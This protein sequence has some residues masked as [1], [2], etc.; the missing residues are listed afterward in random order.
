MKIILNTGIA[1]LLAVAANAQSVTKYVDPYI[2]SGGHGHVFVGASVPFGAVQAGPTNIFK[3]WDWDSGYNYGDSILIGFSHLHL[4]GTGIGDLGDILVMPYT[5]EIK[6]DKGT[7]ANHRSGY[8]SLYSHRNEVVKPGFYS[9]LLEDYNI[10]ASLTATERVGFHRYQFPGGK[11]ARVIVDLKEGTQDKATETFIEKLN[12]STFTGYRYSTGWAK[13]Q[14]VYFAIRTSVPVKNFQVYNEA[15]LLPGTQGKG[16]AGKGLLSFGDGAQTVELKVGISPV[17]AANA[18]GNIEAEVPGWNFD[19]VAQQAD[20]SWN[21]ELSKIEV[22]TKTEKEKRIFYTSLYHTMINPA[23]YNDHNGDYRGADKKVYHDNSFTNYTILSTWDTYRAAH[24]L[25]TLIAPERAADMVNTMLGIYE[26]QGKLPKWHLY[27]YETGTMVGISSMQIVA[28]AYLKGI[29][30]FDAER[31]YKAIKGTAM[32]DS[33]GMMFTKNFKVI[34]NDQYRRSVATAMENAISDASTALMAKQLGH[35][36]DYRYFQRRAANYKLYFDPASG[37]F[38]GRNAAGVM[39]PDFNPVHAPN[40]ELAEGNSW[41]YLWL[42]PQDVTGL[43]TLLGGKKAMAARLDTF[44]SLPLTAE[45]EVLADLTG[46]I[47]Q[48][49]HGN[50][51]GHHI[52]YLYTYVGQPWKTAEKVR[53]I[54]K[55]MYHDQPDGIIGN[56]DCGQ[57]G[58][59]NVFSAMGFYPVFPASGKYVIGSPAV[60]KAVIHTGAG[61]PFVMEAID[62]SPENIYVQSITLNGKAYTKTY[63]LHADLLKGGVLKIKMGNKPNY[64]FGVLKENQPE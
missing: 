21:K 19:Q 28:E 42:V 27:G 8:A 24:P 26:Q 61:E 13:E 57:M 40:P 34:P 23:M 55:E 44:F 25:Y 3:G 33:L 38:R 36:E 43:T 31:A 35:T 12:D 15:Q 54:M 10:R 11:T 32:S 45:K 63:L 9:V 59:W 50:E 60:D 14:Q 46:L 6:T 2:G 7:E 37:F 16:N 17:S 29:K 30:G 62:N 18:L 47:G 39:A 56:E 51:P 48:Y 41:Q 58:A 52:A 4:N 22:T 20:N 53:Y 64:K 5:G 1:L 49:A